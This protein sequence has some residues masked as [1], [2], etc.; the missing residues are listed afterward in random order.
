MLSAHVT[1]STLEELRRRLPDVTLLR[2]GDSFER[3]QAGRRRVVMVRPSS[4]ERRDTSGFGPTEEVWT[5]ELRCYVLGLK[6]AAKFLDLDAFVDEVR[7]A[8]DATLNADDVE[9]TDAA[10]P[11][12]NVV[13]SLQ[14]GPASEQRSYGLPEVEIDRNTLQNVDESTLTIEALVCGAAA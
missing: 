1:R 14:W 4:I 12:P 10:Q 8:C 7:S 6:R 9:I 11:V 3:Q 5:W 13:G 2:P